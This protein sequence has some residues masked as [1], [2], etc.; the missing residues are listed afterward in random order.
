[1]TSSTMAMAT[2]TAALS[3]SI[4]SAPSASSTPFNPFNQTIN[5]TMADGVTIV[6][7]PV[8][9]IDQ[10][11]WIE[12]FQQ[13]ANFGAQMGACIM[14]I[15]VVI[16]MTP[17]NRF[18][19]ASTKINLALLIASLAHASFEQSYFTGHFFEFYILFSGD[20][21][22]VAPVT[23]ATQVCS[24]VAR[25]IQL[26]LTQAALA[27]QAWTMIR[28][29][30]VVGKWLIFF[31]SFCV[32]FLSIGVRFAFNVVDSM[33]VIEANYT[34]PEWME[35]ADFIMDTLS[36]IWFCALFLFKLISHMASNRSSLPATHGLQP[37]DVLVMTNGVLLL[38]PS[39]YAPFFACSNPLIDQTA[40]TH[41][42]CSQLEHV[43]ES[44]LTVLSS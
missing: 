21:S 42:F 17:R 25:M 33:Q 27:L 10:Y 8:S 16:T 40:P 34:F 32:V 1:M 20:I 36:I 31:V 11:Y 13:D 2:T 7:V 28:L 39:M 37:Y 3:S 24:I 22:T 29:W 38:I 15:L 35:R 43:S 5:L 9:L 4:M 26:P 19:K 30:P 44:T 12:G 6:P 23:Y 18:V 14:M 41:C